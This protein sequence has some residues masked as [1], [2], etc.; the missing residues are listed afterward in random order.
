MHRILVAVDFSDSTPQVLAASADMARTEKAELAIL[1]T[2]PLSVP[3][4]GMAWSGGAFSPAIMEGDR[5]D[6]QS[7]LGKLREMADASG[8]P[9]AECMCER[10]SAAEQIRETAKRIHADLIVLGSHR[11]GRLF[12]SMFGSVRDSLLSSAPCPVLV[13][14]PSTQPS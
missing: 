7:S 6:F 5:V 13:I 14:P 11:H 10:G 8:V 12:H 3:M 9:D 4:A 2:M 1:H